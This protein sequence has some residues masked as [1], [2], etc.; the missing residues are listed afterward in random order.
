MIKTKT[1]LFAFITLFLLG[2]TSSKK[3]QKEGENEWFISGL[4]EEKSNNITISGNPKL[5]DSPFGK[6]VSFNGIEDAIFLNKIPLKNAESFTVEMI[7]NPS[8]I[9]A[10]F[11][12]R[13]VH[14]GEVF[15]DRMLLEIR[16]VENNWYFD[17]FVASE[18]NKKALIDDN[19]IHPLGKWYHVALVVTPNSIATYV[20]GKKEL[21]EAFSFKSINTGKSSLGV[22]LNKKSWFKGSI[23]MV[24]ISPQALL[25]QNFISLE[26]L[27]NEKF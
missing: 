21:Q 25:S 20:N 4:L 6:A 26:K 10:P 1:I 17:G 12:Q 14:I 2:C 9:N 16:V 22:R 15:K 27:S 5:V 13:I 23:Y 19:L 3:E 7:F 8:K 11:E 18:K 24:K